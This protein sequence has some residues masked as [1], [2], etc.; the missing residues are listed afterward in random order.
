MNS[1]PSGMI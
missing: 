1:N